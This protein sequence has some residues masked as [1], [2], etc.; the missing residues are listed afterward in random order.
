MPQKGS[1]SIGRF[2]QR[3]AFGR[4]VLISFLLAQRFEDLRRLALAWY[5]R[6]PE[7]AVHGRA[8]NPDPIVDQPLT[9]ITNRVRGSLKC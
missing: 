7:S 9:L 6:G 4:E 5:M 1:P 8:L 3:C 2:R